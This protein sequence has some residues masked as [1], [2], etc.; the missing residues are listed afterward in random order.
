LAE[1]KVQTFYEQEAKIY[2]DTRFKSSH[3]MFVDLVQKSAVLELIGNCKGKRIL[4]IGSGTGRFTK[5]LVKHGAH[6]VCVDLSRPMHEE[7]KKEIATGNIQYFVMSGL[8]LAFEDL[9][10]DCCLTVNMMSH[11]KNSPKLFSEVCRVLKKGGIFVANFPNFSSVYF[12]VGGL[13]NLF[14]RSLQRPVYSRWYSVSEVVR[15]LRSCGLV[16][17][18]SRG[19]LI[20]PKKY[21][22]SPLLTCFKVI[23]SKSSD[24]LFLSGDLFVQ[25]VKV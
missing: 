19:R 17:V 11:I 5:E 8:D 9:S 2:D 21:C 24:I 25:S 16:Y 10:F 13:V 18:N 22:P 7:S 6:V 15:S 20:I 4:E 1:D 12:P 23:N 14:E 3:G